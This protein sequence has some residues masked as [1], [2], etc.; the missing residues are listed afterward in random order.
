MTI[1][2]CRIG[3]LVILFCLTG[4]SLSKHP[5]VLS[6]QSASAGQSSQRDLGDIIA[7][8]L[9]RNSDDEEETQTTPEDTDNTRFLLFP[10]FSSNPALGF[11]GGA[12]ATVTNYWGN[13]LTTRLS[14]TLLSAT[15]TTKKQTLI[16]GRS[17]LYAPNNSWHLAG[18]WRFYDYLEQT[19]GLGSS[20]RSIPSAD[21]DYTWYRLHQVVSRPVWNNLELGIGYHLDTHRGVALATDSINNRTLIT[22]NNITLSN[23][24]SSGVSLNLV[25]DQRDHPLNPTRGVFGKAAYTFY[26][27]RLGSDHDWE[28]VQ[29][30]GRA[31]QPL[32]VNRRQ[33]VALW[34][35]AW[36]TPA[37]H[38]PY[39]DLPS[40]GWDTYGRTARG[41]RSGRVRGRD[42][43]YA[44]GEYR[45]GLTVEDLFGAVSFL[46][47]SR[48][49]DDATS[50]AQRWMPGAGIGLR[51]K[52]DKNRRSNLA[53]DYAW[54]RDGSS[55]LYFAVNE[56]F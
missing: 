31:Y 49:S 14:S 25:F 42:W 45:V 40:V 34:G 53:I 56:A 23:T 47:A 2:Q 12:L 7:A 36:M 48:L 50:H 4:L 19:H 22:E 51:I 16:V 28:S 13:P 5:A 9:D 39:F 46:N 15:V 30:E 54:G 35:L 3:I 11:S 20:S 37:G 6:A 18:D 27:T 55:G 29:L 17:D 26:R 24:T 32:S 33:G 21:V 10:I 44:E 38:P 41:Y 43:L 8:L 52:L 1:Q